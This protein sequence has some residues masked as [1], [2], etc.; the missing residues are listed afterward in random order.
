MLHVILPISTS[1][2]SALTNPVLDQSYRGADDNAVKISSKEEVW[3]NFS[4]YLTE[5]IKANQ[6]A[7]VRLLF[8]I[9]TSREIEDILVI[10]VPK[11]RLLAAILPYAVTE[12][13][14]D[15]KS[16]AC[17][18][19]W[20]EFTPYKKTCRKTVKRSNKKSKPT[21]ASTDHGNNLT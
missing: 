17:K 12:I 1:Y 11:R 2:I 4:Y 20:L 15:K 10:W 5:S 19:S 6:M 16:V 13:I 7:R 18:T 21:R 9:K 3:E 8:L 14:P